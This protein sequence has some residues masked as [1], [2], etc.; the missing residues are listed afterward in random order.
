[1]KITMAQLFRRLKR[2]EI[3]REVGEEL[4]L[5]IE[6]LTE[7]YLQQGMSL[8]DAERAAHECFGDFERVK[9]ECVEI[10]K[11]NNPF[12]RALKSFL[13]AV[14]LTGVLLRVFSTEIHV[15]QVGNMLIVIAA[16]ARLLLY[17]RGLNTLKFQPK[18]E[19]PL[20]LI[21]GK[22]I[23]IEAYDNK[24]LTPVERVISDR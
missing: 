4:Q 24:E 20:S 13:T 16:L 5:H 22:D 17:I 1:M 18:N 3:E 14:F 8:E 9:N 15:M 2:K 11:R 21:H 7:K 23:S 6:L 19:K 12:I 10:T